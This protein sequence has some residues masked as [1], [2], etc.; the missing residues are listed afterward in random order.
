M[1]GCQVRYGW[2]QW[3]CMQGHLWLSPDGSFTAQQMEKNLWLLWASPSVTPKS[4][5]SQLQPAYPTFRAIREAVE[6]VYPNSTK[7]C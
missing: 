2:R 7:D 3:C 4:R 5:L 6:R 1:K